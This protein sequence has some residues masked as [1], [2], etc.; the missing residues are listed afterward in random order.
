MT[1][2]AFLPYLRQYCKLLLIR[3]IFK[4]CNLQVLLRNGGRG[5]KRGESLGFFFLL[6][7]PGELSPS[8]A[9]FWLSQM[10]LRGCSTGAL[11]LCFWLNLWFAVCQCSVGC[12]FWGV[13]LDVKRAPEIPSL[14]QDLA[15]IFID[16]TVYSL[17]ES[18]TQKNIY[19][20][21]FLSAVPIFPGNFR[22]L[23]QWSSHMTITVD[24]RDKHHQGI[25]SNPTRFL[26]LQFSRPCTAD[27][28]ILLFKV[29]FTLFN[30]LLSCKL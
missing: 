24:N 6:P 15:D 19:A 20:N 1:A 13:F 8:P 3:N 14:P 27:F 7:F 16:S 23:M 25:W 12:M 9:P 2:R 28:E 30:K 11:R 4:I 22:S 10:L 5:Q 29:T 17:L 26:S 18:S 21:Y